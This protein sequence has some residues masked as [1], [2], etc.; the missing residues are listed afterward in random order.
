MSTD[1][2]DT[3]R[4]RA[5]YLP[6]IPAAN[7]YALVHTQPLTNGYSVV[8]TAA[9]DFNNVYRDTSALHTPADAVRLA[10]QLVNAAITSDGLDEAWLSRTRAL[11]AELLTD[12]GA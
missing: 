8:V 9:E 12:L 10:E 5:P 4:S 1:H 3:T 7:G 11:F 2:L 6:R